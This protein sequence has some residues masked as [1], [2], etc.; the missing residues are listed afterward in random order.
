MASKTIACGFNSDDLRLSS[1]CKTMFTVQNLKVTLREIS[2]YTVAEN[3]N[4]MSCNH[5]N[6]DIIGLTGILHSTLFQTSVAV[7]MGDGWDNVEREWG[8]RRD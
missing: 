8:W 4:S 2:M 5:T 6:L 1:K 7:G 3:Q